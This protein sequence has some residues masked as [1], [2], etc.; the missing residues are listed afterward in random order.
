[1][2]PDLREFCSN[3]FFRRRATPRNKKPSVGGL[4]CFNGNFHDACNRPVRPRSEAFANSD[5]VNKTILYRL[6]RP[7][8]RRAS[9]MWV[10]RK[11]KTDVVDQLRNSNAQ[12]LGCTG[13]SLESKEIVCDSGLCLSQIYVR[14]KPHGLGLNSRQLLAIFS[15]SRTETY[16]AILDVGRHPDHFC[17][18][19]RA[20][21]RNTRRQRA[22]ATQNAILP[23]FPFRLGSCHPSP[24]CTLPPTHVCAAAH[25]PAWFIWS[26]SHPGR[27][28]RQPFDVA[29]RFLD[30]LRFRRVQG[31]WG[32]RAQD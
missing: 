11:I 7:G 22:V 6:Y 26:E 1:M 4:T 20:W 24:T 12:V 17:H 16:R 21:R 29:P 2:R 3:L 15:L 19:L 9:E 27:S 28:Q 31:V 13:S 5:H 32:A 8:L 18:F 10:R 25:N 30:S 14:L 23:S